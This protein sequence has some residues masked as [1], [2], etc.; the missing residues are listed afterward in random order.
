MT[1]EDDFIT[2]TTFCNEKRNS[3]LPVNHHW[4]R[5]T[6]ETRS[7]RRKIGAY[8]LAPRAVF[9]EIYAEWQ[10]WSTDRKAQLSKWRAEHCDRI[11][12][13]PRRRGALVLPDTLDELLREI[14]ALLKASRN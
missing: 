1:K 2:L 10:A 3:G 5:K 13:I 14:I 9:N 12:S 11:R 8:T 6:L 4:L 7:E